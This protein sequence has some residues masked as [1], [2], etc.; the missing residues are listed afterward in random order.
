M[1]K[2][3][4][5]YIRKTH[6]ILGVFI[7]IQFLGWTISGLFFSW[8]NIDSVHGDHLRKPAKFLSTDVEVVAPTDAV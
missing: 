5:Y 1:K 4:S 8:N 3:A 7:G 2:N 6:R